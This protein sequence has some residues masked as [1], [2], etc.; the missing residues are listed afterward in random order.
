MNV[1]KTL[2]SRLPEGVALAVVV[3]IMFCSFFAYPLY[4]V[5][6]GEMSKGILAKNILFHFAAYGI[7]VL[8]LYGGTVGFGEMICELFSL[9]P[10]NRFIIGG[11]LAAIYFVM[12]MYFVNHADEVK[13]GHE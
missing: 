9:P 6:S 5:I 13:E 7:V 8:W 2:T 10:G 4:C 11:I 12:A 1:I 3:P